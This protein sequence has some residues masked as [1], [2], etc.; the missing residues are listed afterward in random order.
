M[1]VLEAFDARKL[2]ELATTLAGAPGRRF[3]PP[4]ERRT[5]AGE[6]RRFRSILDGLAARASRRHE[7]GKPGID[8]QARVGNVLRWKPTDV[9]CSDAVF[10]LASRPIVTRIAAR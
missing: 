5:D 3:P 10:E 6:V 9:G 1:E 2:G 4:S 8:G 7:N